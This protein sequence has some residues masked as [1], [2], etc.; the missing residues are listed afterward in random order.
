MCGRIRIS[1][2][3]LSAYEIY[4]KN[5]EVPVGENIGPSNKLIGLI[6]HGEKYVCQLMTWGL[7]PSYMKS[8][9]KESSHFNIFNCRIESC[10]EKVVFKSL[11]KSDRCI[12]FI[13]G[14]YEWKNRLGIK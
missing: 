14:F 2:R 7:I 4:S 12:I 3:S 8:D 9:I 10:Q 13:D 6:S 1:I 5:I 11:L